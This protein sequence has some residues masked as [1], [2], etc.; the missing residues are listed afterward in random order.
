MRVSTISDREDM[1][2]YDRALYDGM[3]SL[4]YLKHFLSIYRNV[5]VDFVEEMNK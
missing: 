5:F 4:P 2:I 1:L 3:I